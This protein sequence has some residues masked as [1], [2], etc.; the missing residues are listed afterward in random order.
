MSYRSSQPDAANNFDSINPHEV[1]DIL[2][3]APIGIFKSTPEGRYLYANQTLAQMYGYGSPQELMDSVTDIASQIYADPQ[4]RE[5]FL[6]HIEAYGQVENFE[7]RKLRLNGDMFWASKN[8]RAVQDETGMIVC[9]S[10]FVADISKRKQAEEDLQQRESD[11]EKQKDLYSS[12]VE[13]N[14]LF[15]QR[16][17][18]DTT[19]L[20][21]NRTLSER[22][23]YAFFANPPVGGCVRS[24]DVLSFP[25][26]QGGKVWT[27]PILSSGADASPRRFFAKSERSPSNLG[28]KGVPPFPES[29]ATY[30]TGGRKTEP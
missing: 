4:D 24:Q 19:I 3:H 17:L 5:E 25:S 28:T 30:G 10:G 23:H 18:P 9:L 27:R 29:S 1:N 12:L 15:I 22:E 7:C 13:D 14:P 16:F 6:L 8:V 21:S 20:F 2:H 26:K 11:L